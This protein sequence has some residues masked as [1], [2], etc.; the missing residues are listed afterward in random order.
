MSITII[1]HGLGNVHSVLNMLKH[2]NYYPKIIQNPKEIKETDK[3]ILPG[4]GSA[5]AVWTNLQKKGFVEALR[6]HVEGKKKD[7]LGI[8]VGMQLMLEGSDEG[9]SPGFGWIKGRCKR[10]S[11]TPAYPIKVPHMAWNQVIPTQNK[12]L[13]QH[14]YGPQKFY[15]VH[16]FYADCEN[17]E[18]IA[19]TCKYGHEFAA[20]IENKN[21]L[22][23]Q[24]HPEKSHSFGMQLL[25][26]FINV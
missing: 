18:N 1:D 12:R 15:F 24:F 5:G 11:S 26:N 20:A 19:G 3:V 2:L 23:V 22:G 9:D 6:E 25:Q 7:I 21:I 16:S 14:S 17:K 10:F 8:C 13:F 4:V